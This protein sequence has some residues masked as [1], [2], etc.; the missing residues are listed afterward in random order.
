MKKG[1]TL[2][3]TY[4]NPRMTEER[5]PSGNFWAGLTLFVMGLGVVAIIAQ[6]VLLG[7]LLAGL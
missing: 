2:L 1:D 6:C 5:P 4:R 3:Y 7:L